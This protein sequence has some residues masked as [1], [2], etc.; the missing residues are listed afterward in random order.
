MLAGWLD[1]AQRK[2]PISAP[3]MTP[4]LEWLCLPESLPGSE[5]IAEIVPSLFPSIPPNIQNI[6]AGGFLPQFLSGLYKGRAVRDHFLIILISL[7][8][9]RSGGK[10]FHSSSH[11]TRSTSLQ[12]YLH[13]KQSHSF[14]VLK[15]R[16]P[17]W[18]LGLSLI[19]NLLTIAS[20]SEW[21]WKPVK[22]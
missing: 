7:L 12:P 22:F 19:L 4:F 14:S 2:W 17:Q 13:L 10:M 20:Q 11:V 21:E 5:L 16:W 8:V 6:S 3:I 15:P 18:S 1:I 9:W